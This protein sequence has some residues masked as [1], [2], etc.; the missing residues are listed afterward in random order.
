[1]IYLNGEP[2]VVA[3]RRDGE[4]GV[5]CESRDE[6]IWF[7][8]VG[9]SLTADGGID[10]ILDAIDAAPDVTM[11]CPDGWSIYSGL[12]FDWASDIER[13]KMRGRIDNAQYHSAAIEYWRLYKLADAARA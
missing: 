4:F 2:A 3:A 10:E 5:I 8:G 12:F 11:F 13:A 1:M 9:F 7:D 6:P